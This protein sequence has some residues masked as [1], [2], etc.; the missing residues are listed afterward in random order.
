MT[1][2]QKKASDLQ[3]GVQAKKGALFD[4]ETSIQLRQLPNDIKILL[5]DI[6]SLNP[7]VSMYQGTN[8]IVQLKELRTRL[9]NLQQ[10]EDPA[11]KRYANE[12][13]SELKEIMQKPQ[14]GNKE[15]IKAYNTA[16]AY[17]AYRENILNL[18][19]IKKS[20][21]SDTVEDIVQSK[22]NINNPSEVKYIKEVF[23]EIL[24]HF[25]C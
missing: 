7:Q 3:K 4:T 5:D 6:S 13:F 16:S 9:Y 24:K 2:L 20:L 21:K 11:I 8:P 22:F 19:V 15:F 1:S 10:S 12:L 17:N 18:S 23:K 25:K 14:S